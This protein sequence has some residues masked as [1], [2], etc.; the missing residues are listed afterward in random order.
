[1][2]NASS[3][4]DTDNLD[5]PAPAAFSVALL[6][7]GDVI[8]DFLDT[9]GLSFEEFQTQMS[10]GWLFGLIEALQG[11]GV[12]PV[13]VCFSVGVRAPKRLT[14]TP[15]GA[16]LWVLPPSRLFKTLRRW[17][18]ALQDPHKR[19][20][21]RTL[22][23]VVLP[24]LQF[25]LPRLCTPS[26]V[27]SFLLK[28]EKCAAIICQEYEYAR[29]DACVGSGKRSGVPVFATFQGGV[30]PANFIERAIRRA[31]VRA[32]AGLVIAPLREI[33][34]VRAAYG[35]AGNQIARI[36][37]PIS[38]SM[39]SV[40]NRTEERKRGRIELGIPS[41]ALVVICHGRIEMHRK[42]LDVL[43]EA[44][45]M[46]TKARPE[47]PLRLLL[48]GTGSDAARMHARIE[49]M[50][51]R[52]VVWVDRYVLD[53]AEM[54]RYLSA[55]DVS[56]LP[57]RHEGFPVAPLE[58][59]ACGLP[60]VA[61]DAPGVSDILEEGELSGGLVVPRED[62]PALAQALGRLLDDEL[63]RLRLAGRASERVQNHFSLEVVGQKWRT[64]LEERG[65]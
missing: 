45:Q 23:R 63:L 6:P 31:T 54:K 38:L 56:V 3:S 61:A 16:T 50:K 8:E 29:F 20:L 58:A 41:D 59:M 4:R 49:E 30:A 57:S 34:R 32:G 36:F 26:R 62:A 43:L 12:R 64:F 48:V 55:A 65:L 40:A 2:P 22:R 21:P 25:V 51:L 11:A 39:W 60:V 5:S 7:W 52:G 27:F 24:V 44:W 42:G 37:N 10:G 33:E 9:I 15:T 28:R 46:V 47:V 53:R 1:M 14:H 19:S 17:S 18:V 13:L 35:V